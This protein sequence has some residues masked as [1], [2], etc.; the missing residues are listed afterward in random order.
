MPVHHQ[1]KLL[2]EFG[3]TYLAPKPAIARAL[4]V[5]LVKSSRISSI[6]NQNR[7]RWRFGGC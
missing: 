5:S 1:L 7:Q 3:G 4:A 2:I 6:E